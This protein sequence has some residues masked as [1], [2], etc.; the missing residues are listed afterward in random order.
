VIKIK[1]MRIHRRIG[2]DSLTS[3]WL[4]DVDPG[5]RMKFMHGLLIIQGICNGLCGVG[6]AISYTFMPI[7]DATAIIFSSPLP[8]MLLSRIFLKERLGLYMVTCG[9]VLY[10][11]VLLVVHPPFLF[12]H[13]MRY[14]IL[15]SP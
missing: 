11:G 2:Q 15:I 7:G 5:R 13:S 10:L 1:N 14:V 3:V 8:S 12:H 9:L 6:E 4:D